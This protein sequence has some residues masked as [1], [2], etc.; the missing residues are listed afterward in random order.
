LALLLE[1][2]PREFLK[3]VGRFWQQQAPNPRGQH[4]Q[5]ACIADLL[6]LPGGFGIPLHRSSI[7]NPEV[8]FALAHGRT[9]DDDGLG[10]YVSEDV[11]GS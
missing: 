7:D 5:L 10:V 3:A 1:R 6:E 2:H 4:V 8:S 9:V 11:G